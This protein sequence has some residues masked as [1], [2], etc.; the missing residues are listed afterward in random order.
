MSDNIKQTIIDS[1]KWTTENLGFTLIKEDWG[2]ANRKCTC[3]MGCVLLKNDPKDLVII[4]DEKKDNTVKAAEILGVDEDWI[5]SF[6]EG[7]DTSGSVHE[8]KVPEA[9]E[10]GAEVSKETSP[11]THGDWLDQQEEEDE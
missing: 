3:A 1:I 5:N 10:L 9:W 2:T 7:F 11:I 4:E 8:A 6:I